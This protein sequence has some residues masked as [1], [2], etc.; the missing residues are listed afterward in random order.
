MLKVIVL[1]RHDIDIDIYFTF[2]TALLVV[3]IS[4]TENALVAILIFVAVRASTL[5]AVDLFHCGRR[6]SKRPISKP[7]QTV[8]A[9]GTPSPRIAN[10]HLTFM[11]TYSGT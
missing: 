3:A 2:I 10:R 9:L 4:V 7:E 6:Y 8:C 5:V 11:S 1:A